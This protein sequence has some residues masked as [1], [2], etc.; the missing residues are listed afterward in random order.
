MRKMVEETH[1]DA[2]A[3]RRESERKAA[4][5]NSFQEVVFS[6]R[7]DVDPPLWQVGDVPCDV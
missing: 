6:A 2:L 3:N 4:A 7:T 1:G 5:T